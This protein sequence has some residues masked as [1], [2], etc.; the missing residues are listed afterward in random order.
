[1]GVL[2]IVVVI[3]V[4]EASE[5]IVRLIMDGLGCVSNVKVVCLL[6]VVT[7]TDGGCGSRSNEPTSSCCDEEDEDDAGMK[8]S[9]PLNSHSG[10]YSNSSIDGQ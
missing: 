6:K 3:R 2:G 5:L 1:M 10:V 7:V 8:P 9:C 4:V